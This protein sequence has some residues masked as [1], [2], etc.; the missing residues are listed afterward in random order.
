V[1]LTFHS[2]FVTVHC[3]QSDALH[4]IM[5]LMR[6]D[7]CRVDPA[8]VWSLFESSALHPTAAT[9]CF[10]ATFLDK[11]GAPEHGRRSIVGAS[12]YGGSVTGGLVAAKKSVRSR[13]L[14][15]IATS[16]RTEFSDGEFVQAPCHL[17]AAL[18]AKI[19]VAL[20]M[21]DARL[22]QY[23]CMCS[24]ECTNAADV[25]TFSRIEHT[26]LLTTFHRA[27]DLP[28]G[29]GSETGSG[30]RVSRVAEGSILHCRQA[31]LLACLAADVDYFVTSAKPE[32]RMA[33]LT[34]CEAF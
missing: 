26:C 25:H 11:N 30:G 15:W 31:E 3:T 7:L 32:V 34:A 2:R 19:L 22:S 8:D 5:C 27:V 10:L 21:R 4:L 1:W 6:Y 29:V 9:V 28:V 17:D 23:Q 20:T 24:S 13:L 12:E 18:A 14:N 33:E 16:S